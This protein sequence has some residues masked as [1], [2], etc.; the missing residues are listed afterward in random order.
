MNTNEPERRVDMAAQIA[1]LDDRLTVLERLVQENT[2]MTKD[3][4]DA[5]TAGRVATKVIKWAGAIALASSAIY[6]AVYQAT[7]GG[8]L[9]HQ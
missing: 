2:E 6:A 5:V 4:R 8:K 7:H 9:P 3:I 1:S